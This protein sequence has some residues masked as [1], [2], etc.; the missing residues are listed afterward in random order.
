MIKW[1]ANQQAREDAAEKA[2]I[3]ELKEASLRAINDPSFDWSALSPTEKI[4]LMCG[5][6]RPKP[7]LAAPRSLRKSG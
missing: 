1:A 5:P 2:A 3:R 4:K 7:K 6:P